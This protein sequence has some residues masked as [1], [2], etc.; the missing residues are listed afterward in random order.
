LQVSAGGSSES[1]LVLWV[2]H[3]RAISSSDLLHPAGLALVIAQRYVPWNS[4]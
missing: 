4:D 3:Q 1:G 2:F